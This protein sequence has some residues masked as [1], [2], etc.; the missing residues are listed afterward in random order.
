[1]N[2]CAALTTLAYSSRWLSRYFAPLIGV[3]SERA[4]GGTQQA[5]FTQADLSNMTDDDLRELAEN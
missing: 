4:T 5:G 3:R 1:M 2:F